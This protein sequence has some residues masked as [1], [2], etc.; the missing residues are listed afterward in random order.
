LF[1]I[2]GLLTHAPS[3][4]AWTNPTTNSYRRLVPGYEAPTCCIF[5]KGNRSAAIRIPAYAT[6]ANQV[7]FEFR[8][9]DATCNPYLAMAA[10]LLAGIDG[11]IKKIDPSRAGFGP[12]NEDIFA[13]SP[14]KRAGIKSLP[15]SLVEA[16]QALQ[17]D[18]QYLLAGD[19]FD[20]EMVNDWITAKVQEEDELRKRPHPFEIQRYF[21]L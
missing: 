3:V 14:E 8:P 6:K 7:R 15:C 17:S 2:G 9:P 5:S 4:L 16:M 21:D 10:M 1:F 11:I 20:K 13:W 18:H 19:V 12:I